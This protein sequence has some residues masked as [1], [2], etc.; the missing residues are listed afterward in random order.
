ME[1]DIPKQMEIDS[2]QKYLYSYLKNKIQAKISQ[3]RWRS[4]ILINGMIHQEDKTI[5]KLYAVN[6]QFHKTTGHKGTDRT[7]FINSG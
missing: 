1:N 2:K 4:L 6:I 5:A 7:R 3:K